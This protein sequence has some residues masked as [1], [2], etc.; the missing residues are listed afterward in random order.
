MDVK[1]MFN[2]MSAVLCCAAITSGSVSLVNAAAVEGE[3]AN[4]Q[5]STGGIWK[6]P[7]ETNESLQN[8]YSLNTITTLPSSFDITINDAT[9]KYFPDIG[10]KCDSRN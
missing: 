2:K 1:R 4:L 8:D 7:D 6:A 3:T 10:D 5:Y 9:E